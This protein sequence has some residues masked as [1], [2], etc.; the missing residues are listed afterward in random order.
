MNVRS[1]ERSYWKVE[2]LDRFDGVRW[3]R[4][5]LGRGNNPL[6]PAPY[7]LTWETSLR[8]TIRDLDT[9]LFP[10]AGTA[11]QITGADP[12]A[13]PSED[14]TVEALGESLDE[15][16]SYSVDAYV[17]QPTPSDMRAAPSVVPSALLTYTQVEDL[18]APYA[19]MRDL[20]LR[21]ARGQPSTYDIVRSVQAH[22][23]TEYAYGER[24]PRRK[25]PLPAFL[26]R[27]RIGYCQQF[28]GAMAL[29]LRMLGIPTR[30]A[31]GFTP[32]S[33]NA[34]TREYRV[35][36]LDA[37][38][39]PEVWFQGIGW[40]PFEPTPSVAP[41]EAQSDF[42]AA[43]ASG[44]PTGAAETPDPTGSASPAQ[45]E[46]A[47]GGGEQDGGAPVEPWMG[48]AAMALLG[49]AAL[50]A[51]RLL[52]VFRRDRRL[53]VEEAE[54]A[55]L[56]SVL[57]RTGEPATSR[58]TLR[59]LELR[60]ETAGPAATRYVRMLRERRYGARGGHMPDGAARRQLRRALI[61]GR[62][63]RARVGALAAMPPVP[64]RR[65]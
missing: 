21:L 40:V 45:P 27:D 4:S 57:A 2:T 62:G 51:L 19:P 52:A 18:G 48:L 17:P 1:V 36:D 15:G 54:L 46:S 7:D 24:P 16:D 23:R 64:F 31:A 28:S 22:L 9:N 53:G 30:V 37:H 5:G 59:Q 60:M 61:R 39:W 3:E 11:L 14:G 33:Y 55:A 43:S 13:V 49:L 47:G 6:L 38:S 12:V 41:A 26:F 29:M 42:D 44:G 50:G 58:L 25:F 65:G 20:A 34:D 8:V 35:R 10:I 32:G 56:R 63:L